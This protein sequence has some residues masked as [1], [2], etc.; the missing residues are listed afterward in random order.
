MCRDVSALKALPYLRNLNLRSNPLC[1]GGD[2]ALE[3]A[4]QSAMKSTY[5]LLDVFDAK[6]VKAKSNPSLYTPE[7]KA[8]AYA[9]TIA[10]MKAK[11]LGQPKPAKTKGPKNKFKPAPTASAASAASDGVQEADDREL[12]GSRLLARKRARQHAPAPSSSAASAASAADDTEAEA[13]VDDAP[14]AKRQRI[15]A[16][17]SAPAPA[18]ARATAAADEEDDALDLTEFVARS[19]TSKPTPPATTT[20]TKPS[21]AAASKPSA[22][23]PAASAAVV[24]ADAA[25]SAAPKAL[26]RREKRAALKDPKQQPSKPP[27]AAAAAPAST[28][29]APAV[30]KPS[31]NKAPAHTASAP[32]AAGDVPTF[33]FAAGAVAPD[34]VDVAEAQ[35]EETLASDKTRYGSDVSL[36]ATAHFP[37]L[38]SLLLLCEQAKIWCSV[39]DGC[40]AQICVFCVCGC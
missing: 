37:S 25:V 26:T 6:R 36:H 32:T 2:A 1:G 3:A 27:A 28:K 16:P 19:T 8:A 5:P 24:K 31:K 14:R 34:E 12:E 10:G 4:Y 29:P 15:T 7:T 33:T 38:F 11:A 30:S 40:E 21:K 17:A 13:A 20:S 35:I 23:S 39:S 18:P 9:A 22:A